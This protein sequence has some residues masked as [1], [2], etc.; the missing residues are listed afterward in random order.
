MKLIPIFRSD[1]DQELELQ[2]FGWEVTDIGEIFVEV[3][4]YTSDCNFAD[5]VLPVIFDAAANGW[6][7]IV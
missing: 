1:S 5:A 3:M 4:N 2:C 6:C 7:Q